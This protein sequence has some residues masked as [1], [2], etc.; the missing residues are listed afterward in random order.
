MCQALDE[1]ATDRVSG[2][3]HHDR[4]RVACAHGGDDRRVAADH[5][6]VDRESRQFGRQVAEAIELA[7]GA[8]ILHLKVTPFDIAEVAQSE[9]KLP[10]QVGCDRVGRS[11]RIEIAEADDLRLLC[12]CRER[13]RRRRTA[14]YGQQLPPSDGDCHTP[15][16][17]RGA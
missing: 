14:K 3:C 6:H 13:P 12:A 7:V 10:A 2:E 16:P 9:E 11:L 17:A 15:P 5:E 8:A 1:A 4:D